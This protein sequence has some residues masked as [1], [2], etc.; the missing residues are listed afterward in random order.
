VRILIDYRPALRQRT[1]VGEYAHELASALKPTLTAGDSMVLFSSSWKDRLSPSVLPD[2]PIVDAR[3]PVTLLN[4]VWHRLEWPPIESLAGDVDVAHSMHPLLMPA[5]AAAQIVTI[6]DLYFLDNAANTAAEIKRDYPALAASHARR[7]DAV[8]T[9]SKYTASQ[10]EDRLGVDPR[11]I[12]ICPPG[13]PQWTPIDRY[14]D[15]G[16]ILFMGTIEP[17]K[18]VETLLRAYAMLAQRRPHAPPLVLAGKVTPACAH[19]LKDF[20]LPVLAGR[21]KAVGYVSGSE[22]ERMYREASMLV[23]PS[24]DEGFGM[25]ALEAMTIGLPVVASNRG[26]LPEV[27]GDA[28]ILVDPGDA[29]AL[30]SAMERYLAQPEAARRALGAGRQ[31]AMLFSWRAS[32]ASLVRAY[33]DAIERRRDRR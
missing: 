24:L 5:R 10:I 23:L 17:R 9:I 27:I 11:R 33:E 15:D 29:G 3:V 28:G 12:T 2:V 16:P 22:R 14:A 30:A 25:P 20:E 32:A 8:I 4:L 13:A 26:A 18:N 1:G 21:V 6:Y 31:R 19:L 7:A